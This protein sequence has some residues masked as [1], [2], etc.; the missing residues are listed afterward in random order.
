[1]GATG[2]PSVL[3]VGTGEYTTGWAGSGAATSDKS[4]GIVA[5]VCLDLKRRGKIRRLGMCGT[6][7][8]KL[9]AIR[10][11]MQSV[12][13]EVYSGIEPSE[14]ETWPADGTVD[15]EAYKTAVATFGPGDCAIIFTPDDTHGPIATA[16]MD[17][18]MHVMITKP[19]VKTLDEHRALAAAAKAADRLCVVE[20]RRRA[21]A[22]AA[23]PRLGR[24][25][26]GLGS[27]IGVAGA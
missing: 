3:M 15:R 7:G 6:D 14:I 20:A 19:P 1:M 9:P 22:P 5:L 10:R 17:A 26:R 16:C 25:A 2:A 11:H 18:G 13:G 12:L 24:A 21:R 8:N 27:S 23:I 4:T